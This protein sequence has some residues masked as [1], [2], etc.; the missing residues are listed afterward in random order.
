MSGGLTS[1]NDV[2]VSSVPECPTPVCIA[3]SR[4]TGMCPSGLLSGC[5]PMIILLSRDGTCCVG[6]NT[7]TLAVTDHGGLADDLRPG[8]ARW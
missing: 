4:I 7:D 3:G 6:L 2:Q 8:W 1:T 5:G